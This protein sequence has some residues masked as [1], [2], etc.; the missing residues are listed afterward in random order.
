MKIQ[1]SHDEG[2]FKF[3]KGDYVTI[4][5]RY[6]YVYDVEDELYYH[7][8]LEDIDDKG[9]WCVIDNEKQKEY[10]YFKEIENVIPGHLIPFLGGFT[11]R[12][13]DVGR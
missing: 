13:T 4:I 5:V 3:V 8:T 7:A 11:R 1:Y 12:R 2:E 10:F 6:L 9:F